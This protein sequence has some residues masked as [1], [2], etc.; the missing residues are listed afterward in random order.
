MLD[1]R[2]ACADDRGSDWR[3]AARHRL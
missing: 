1:E 3:E 2:R